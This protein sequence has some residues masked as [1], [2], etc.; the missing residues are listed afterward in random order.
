MLR[1]GVF[2][3]S[4]SRFR[5][6]AAGVAWFGSR[7][8]SPSPRPRLGLIPI[9]EETREPARRP[10]RHSVYCAIARWSQRPH[11]LV[12]P[13][14]CFVDPDTEVVSYRDE[15]IFENSLGNCVR[16]DQD[17]PY[18]MLPITS[19]QETPSLSLKFPAPS[20]SQLGTK[21]TAQ[22]PGWPG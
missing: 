12:P 16:T 9:I 6:A 1:N 11:L 14:G 13:A 10:R 8:D 21:T 3:A 17:M 20:C 22:S 2:E 15:A 5:S 7:T 19:S 4:T 18:D